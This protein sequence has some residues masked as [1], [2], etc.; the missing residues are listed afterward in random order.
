MKEGIFQNEGEVGWQINTLCFFELVEEGI[1]N[2]KFLVE[3]S[4]R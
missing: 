2:F 1:K 3:K 4:K